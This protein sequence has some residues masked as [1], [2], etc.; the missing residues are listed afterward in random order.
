VVPLKSA[1]DA[2]VVARALGVEKELRPEVVRKT[3]VARSS[4]DGST[5]EVVATFESDDLKSLTSAV[6]SY[7]LSLDVSVRTVEAFGK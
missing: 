5:H 7:H 3:I 1:R 2:E 4:A 6:S